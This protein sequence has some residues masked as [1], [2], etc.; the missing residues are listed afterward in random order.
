MNRTNTPLQASSPSQRAG[1]FAEDAALAILKQQGHTLVA[2]NVYCR[3]GEI[4]LITLHNHCLIFTEVRWRRSCG[5]GGAAASLTAQ[6]QQR[7]IAAA[8]Y[9]LCKEPHWQSYHLRFD[10]M[11]FEGQPPTWQHQWIQAAF[12]AF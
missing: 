8:R 1:Q 9:F 2:R 11:L 10:A 5:F 7:I 4:D 12:N 6:K 3:R